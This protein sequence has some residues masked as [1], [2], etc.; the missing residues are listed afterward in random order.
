LT[1]GLKIQPGRIDL[2]KR[3]ITVMTDDGE[4]PVE[5]ISQGTSSLMGWV[6]VLL[7]RLYDVYGDG[8]EP[9]ARNALVLID[10]IDAHMHPEWQQ[11]V[12]PLV[13]KLF[14]NAQVI[15]TTHSP[16]IVPSLQPEEIIRL[17]R[18]PG[19][20]RI[21]VQFPNYNVR[22]Y[23][24]DQ[25]LTSPLFGL[26]SSLSPEMQRRVRLYTDLA[27]RDELSAEEEQALERLAYD[28]G[29]KLPSPAERIEARIA[30]N[31]IQYA[32]NKHI[33]HMEPA[34]TENVTAELKVQLQELITGSRR[35]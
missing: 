1:P 21:S 29:V 23:R 12:A 8:D 32:L 19:E 6:G 18:G 14:P 13:R 20:N 34:L 30:Y 26:E 24:A 3:A 28:I 27:A 16:L 5:S 33:E 35:P 4:V 11:F 22:D 31:L 10:E 15:A 25:V 17:K 2:D 7:R 9:L